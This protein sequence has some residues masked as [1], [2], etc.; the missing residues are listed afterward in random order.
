MNLG[1]TGKPYDTATGLYNYG[2]RD[3]KPE[4]ARFTTVDP[5]RDGS[6][7]FAYVN[8]DPVNFVDLWGLDANE[9]KIT[10][11]DGKTDTKQ[12]GSIE[13]V[14]LS[15]V[16]PE[17]NGVKMAWAGTTLDTT[18]GSSISVSAGVISM[19]GQTNTPVFIGGSFDV[20]NAG[21]HIAIINDGFGASMS[22][23]AISLGGNVGTKV[24]VGDREIKVSVGASIGYQAGFELSFTKTG[25]VFDVSF[26]LGARIEL[27]WKK[28][29]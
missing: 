21:G 17:Q 9:P 27:S 23:S 5:I 19:Q 11:W 10:T 15:P 13:Q 26:L 25:F 29:E 22:A 4:L 18:N 6:N 24:D 3:Y 1:Y 2:Y 20:A 16:G 14:Y 28:K 8:N 7:W 12:Y